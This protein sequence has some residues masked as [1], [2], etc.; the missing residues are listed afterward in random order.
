MICANGDLLTVT[1]DENGTEASKERTARFFDPEVDPHQGIGRALR[2]RMAVRFF[3]RHA[4]FHRCFRCD[5]PGRRELVPAV[6]RGPGAELAHRPGA[7]HSL[8]TKQS[9]RL[10]VLARQDDEPLDDPADWDGTE[11]WSFDLASRQ[12]LQRLEARPASSD[13]GGA[14]ATLGSTSGDGASNILVAQ[15]DEP[16]LVSAGRYGNIRPGCIHRGISPRTTAERT[17][18]RMA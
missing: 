16:L 3:R 18:R 13:A 14:G 7:S 2:G 5:A 9:G 8:F 12:R 11:I 10:Y 17:E 4:P 15:G 6:G 1:L